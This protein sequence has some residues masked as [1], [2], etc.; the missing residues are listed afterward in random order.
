MVVY[1]MYRLLV[2]C[3]MYC[4]LVL[5]SMYYCFLVV[6][7]NI[8]YVLFIS[9]MQVMVIVMYISYWIPYA[10]SKKVSALTPTGK[11]EK[12]IFKKRGK[13][14]KQ[15]TNTNTCSE[16]FVFHSSIL[17]RAFLEV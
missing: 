12:S 9:S 10:V 16:M 4:L 11:T 15:Q 1:C 13:K 7:S 8:L 17:S 14:N 5:D 3:C 2:V 6:D